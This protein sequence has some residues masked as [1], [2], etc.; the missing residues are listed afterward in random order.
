VTVIDLS[1]GQVI[2]KLPT[3]AHQALRDLDHTTAYA[4]P[5][6]R[7]DLRAAVADHYRRRGSTTVHADHLTVTAGARHGLFVTTATVAAGGEVLIP[8]PHWSHYPKLVTRAGAVPVIVP[9][10]PRNDWRTDPDRLHAARTPRTKAILLNSPVNPTGAVYPPAEADAIRQWATG[11]GIHVIT[12]DIYWAYGGPR[13]RLE[14]TSSVTIVGGASKVHAA[15]G[16]RVGWTW[17]TA[18]FTDAIRDAVEHTTG[19]VCTVAQAIAAAIVIDDDDVEV[20][21]RQIGALR[22]HA[23]KVFSSVPHI[24]PLHPMGGIYLCLDAT[25]LIDSARLPVSDDRQLCVLLVDRAQVR[26]RAGST[27]GLPG[28]LRLCVATTPDTLQDAAARLA[29]VLA[30]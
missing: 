6:G 19:P 29:A 26:L 3:R 15:A 2:E 18:A 10:D 17:S 11:E 21:A 1:S 13:D 28:H 9:G 20:R 30:D 16:L 22:E 4:E 25:A 24:E 8:A 7:R 5:A 14:A 23:F 27:F 12:D